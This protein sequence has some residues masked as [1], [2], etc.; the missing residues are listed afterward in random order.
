MPITDNRGAILITHDAGA[1]RRRRKFR[2][3][4]HVFLRCHQLDALDLLE[5][6]IGEVEREVARHE[7]G[8]VEV[9]ESGVTYHAP[10]YE[11]G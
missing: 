7:I 5:A 8:V 9:R 11:I 4:R 1:T 2:F 3:G 6:H 10:R